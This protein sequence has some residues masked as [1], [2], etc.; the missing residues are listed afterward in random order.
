LWL[1]VDPQGGEAEGVRELQE[2]AA[3]GRRVKKGSQDRILA[4]VQMLE[5]QLERLREE[6]SRARG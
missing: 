5:K 6:V 3:V 4:Y 1:H 2:E